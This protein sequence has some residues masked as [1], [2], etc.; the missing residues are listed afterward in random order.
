MCVAEVKSIT[1]ANE[2]RQLRLGL[3]QVLRYRQVLTTRGSVRP[4]L[5]IERAPQD[6]SWSTLC[7]ELGV[8]LVWPGHWHGALDE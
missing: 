1:P 2:E 4:I 3:G 5:A 8:R 6:V 7:S